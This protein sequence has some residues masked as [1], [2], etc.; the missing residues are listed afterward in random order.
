MRKNIIVFI[1]LIFS[2]MICYP[3]QAQ[4]D[5]NDLSSALSSFKNHI[6]GV[7]ILNASQLTEQ[8]AIVKENIELIGKN[9]RIISLAFDLV[10]LYEE[11]EGPLFLNSRTESGISPNDQTGIE[12]DWAIFHIQQGII[13]HIYTPENIKHYSNILNGIKFHTAEYFPGDVDPPSDHT[14]SFKVDVD[15]SMPE[16]WWG[17]PVAYSEDFARRPTGSY[18]APGSIAT[19]A[20]PSSIVDKG[21]VIRVGAHSWDHV[22]RPMYKRLNRVSLVYP[23]TN[24]KTRIANP[25]GGGIYIEVPYNSEYGVLPV[26]IS[27]AVRT[28]FFSARSFNKTSLADWQNTQ[29]HHPGPWADF[30]SD[31]FMMQI[32]TSWLYN[33]DDPVTLMQNWDMSMDSV[34]ELFGLPLVRN[35]TVLYIQMDVMMRGGAFFPGYPQSNYPYNPRAVVNGNKDHFTLKGPQFASEITFHE[36][37]HAQL[38]TKFSGETEAA[39]NLPYV[40]VQNIKFGMSLDEAFGKSFGNPNISLEQAAIMWMVTENFRNGNP[41]DITNTTKNE[42][43]YQHRGY[44]KYVEIARIFGWDTL[45]RFWGSVQQDYLNGITYP[46]NSDPTDSRI[47][48]MS[49]AADADLT[50]LIHFWGVQPDDP[51]ALKASIAEAGI[52]PSG[53]IY[54]MLKHYQTVIPMNNQEFIGHAEII[55]PDGLK[56]AN[57]D[58]G[59]GWYYKN[60]PKYNESHGNLAVSALDN[61]I[62]LYFP[63]GRPN[64]N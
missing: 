57:P 56:E 31:K 19:V 35:I 54:D 32:P 10:K 28:P 9:E 20:V 36:L 50:P 43:R 53:A 15:F 25:L 22:D 47:L 42:V 33:F 8:T 49:K 7:S 55:Y 17:E 38:F 27:N 59:I 2:L 58:Y 61:I 23:I 12:L 6:T 13:D 37:G 1:N 62:K 14:S 60:V 4:T 45:S 16:V 41:M 3:I 44:G 18:L 39:V 29:R 34:S 11:N 30:E 46:R 48:R 21:F 40:A 63:D 26:E 64:L 52:K 51:A 24:T 5:I